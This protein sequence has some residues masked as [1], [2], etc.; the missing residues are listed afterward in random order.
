MKNLRQ[1]TAIAILGSLWCIVEI[2]GD[3]LLRS[4]QVPIRGAFL[5]SFGVIIL[6]I[7]RFTIPGQWVI[8]IL[9]VLTASL[10]LMILG[11]L[12]IWPSLGILIET[13][14]VQLI[15]LI[16]KPRKIQ[17]V[18]A[19]ALGVIWSFFHP[20]VTQGLI[21]GI[22]IYQVYLNIAQKGMD[23]LRMDMI[24]PLAFLFLWFLIHV[25]IGLFA[26]FSAWQLVKLIHKRVSSVSNFSHIQI[27]SFES[28]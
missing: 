16:G 25:A 17:V 23:V 12:S 10:K 21:A 8:L 22:G 14:I 11:V 2:Y 6:S 7:A 1:I 19:G 3:L 18:S 26:G 4:L 5:M 15:F 28:K 27:S 20:F 24:S 9:G 13:F